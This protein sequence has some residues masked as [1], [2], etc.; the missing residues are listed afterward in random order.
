MP[1]EPN[2]FRAAFAPG[3]FAP[4]DWPGPV[5]VADGAAGT[6]GRAASTCRAVYAI[7]SGARTTAETRT[8]EGN[9]SVY[10]NAVPGNLDPDYSRPQSTKNWVLFGASIPRSHPAWLTFKPP[11]GGSSE[12]LLKRSL[13]GDELFIPR[14]DAIFYLR[15]AEMQ[16]RASRFGQN[17]DF[18]F[19]T[20]DLT[21]SGW[22]PRVMGV[23][24]ARFDLDC[25]RRLL[26]VSL[27]VRGEKRYD[28]AVTER[29]PSGWPEDWAGDIP[30]TAR[31]YRLYAYNAAFDLKNF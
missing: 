16:T 23:V 26:Q 20:N 30:E 27:L 13:G 8:T 7:S 4:F 11:A 10:V 25:D 1:K 9:F 21:G 19:F 14:N 22:Q 28:S 2:D 31:R 6:S 12:L 18:A 3:V 17:D 5:S 15:A 29:T 24:D